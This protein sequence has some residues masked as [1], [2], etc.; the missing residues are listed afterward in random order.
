MLK[1]F[2]KETECYALAANQIGIQKR[3]IYLKNTTQDI[4]LEN[5]NYDEEKIIINP[6]VLSKK[7]KT[8][9]WEPCLSC[10][11]F[12]GLVTRPHEIPAT[13]AFSG[14]PAAISDIHDA[15]VEAIDVEPFD[16]NV[17]DTALI[18]YGNSS[19]EG[20]TG[21]SA[22]SAN[23]PCPISLLPGPL[24]TFVSPTEYAGKLY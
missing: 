7:G 16:S 8:K 6:L 23:A 13:I 3:I 10:L 19:S 22:L 11:D 14:T 12:M 5:I 18:E 20:S 15:H 2:C 9:Y 4:P 1:E 24:E 17:S 21:I